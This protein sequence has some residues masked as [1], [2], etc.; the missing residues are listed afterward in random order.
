MVLWTFIPSLRPFHSWNP[1]RWFHE[2][3]NGPW[4]TW[5]DGSVSPKIEPLGILFATPLLLH[6]IWWLTRLRN[7]YTENSD[8]L[9]FTSKGL[10]QPFTKWVSTILNHLQPNLKHLLT[11]FCA[12]TSYAYFDDFESFILPELPLIFESWRRILHALLTTNF[13]ITS[14][15][16]ELVDSVNSCSSST[17]TNHSG[18]KTWSSIRPANTLHGSCA[19]LHFWGNENKSYLSWAFKGKPLNSLS[20]HSLRTILLHSFQE[21]L[22]R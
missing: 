4:L 18:Y 20:T 15:E 13:L 16:L 14:K 9:L 17:S 2:W 12:Q 6:E 8:R 21:H 22:L 1:N 10:R 19:Q 3:S 11:T 5:I 7:F